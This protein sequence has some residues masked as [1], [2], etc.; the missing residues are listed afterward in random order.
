MIHYNVMQAKSIMT[1]TPDYHHKVV[2]CVNID[3]A[4]QLNYG[5]AWG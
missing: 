1:V 4:N 5:T 3:L 2:L